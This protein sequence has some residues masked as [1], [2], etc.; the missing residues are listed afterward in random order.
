VLRY[1]PFHKGSDEA[2]RILE[3]ARIQR[4]F[5]P[6][7]EALLKTQPAWAVHG[8]PNLGVAW[9]AAEAAGLNVEQARRDMMRAEVDQVLKQDIADIKSVKVNRTPTFFVNSKPL[10]SFGPGPLNDLVRS[11]VEEARG[12]AASQ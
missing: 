6:V 1:A 2:V 8:A 4:K 10:T 11:E 3:A 5:E 7:L 12:K 9:Q